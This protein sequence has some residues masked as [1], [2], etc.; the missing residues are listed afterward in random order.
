M[1]NEPQKKKNVDIK[2][3]RNQSSPHQNADAINTMQFSWCD[4]GNENRK[5]SQI[6]FS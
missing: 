5:G 6:I 1:N 2:R 4:K 3:R